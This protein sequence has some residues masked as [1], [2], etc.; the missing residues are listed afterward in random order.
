MLPQDL[1]K[2]VM[3]FIEN[4]IKKAGINSLPPRPEKND[5]LPVIWADDPDVTVLFGL[6]KKEPINLKDIRKK[7]W[8]R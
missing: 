5:D 1:R 6:R 3:D 2:E 7:A 8:N 4:L